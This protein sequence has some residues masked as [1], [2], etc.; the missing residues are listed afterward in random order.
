MEMGGRVMTDN[1]QK[2]PEQPPLKV[3]RVDLPELPE[4]FADSIDQVFFDGQT[5][6]INFGVTRFDQP[7][8]AS[9]YPACRLV[10]P[11][12]AA[13]EL[14]NQMQKLVTGLIQAGVLKAQPASAEGRQ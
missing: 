8:S 2:K 9:R 11:P 4:T 1:P 12:G 6:R 5:V 7:S 3:Q 10:L 14:M 13:V